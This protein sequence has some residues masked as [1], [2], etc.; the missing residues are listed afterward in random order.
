MQL[1]FILDALF[2]AC[3]M[4][5]MLQDITGYCRPA[6]STANSAGYIDKRVTI[7][8]RGATARITLKKDTHAPTFFI[9]YALHITDSGN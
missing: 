6:Q 7:K 4:R 2:T 3:T 8:A 1:V 5:R 9:T